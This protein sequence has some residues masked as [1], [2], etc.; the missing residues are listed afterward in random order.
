MIYIE[1]KILNKRSDDNSENDKDNY[2]IKSNGGCPIFKEFR[3]SLR[4]LS[5]GKR[6]KAF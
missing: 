6:L 2:K 5:L 3:F 1:L 4:V